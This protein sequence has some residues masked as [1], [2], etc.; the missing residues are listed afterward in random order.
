MP[1]HKTN[2][3][4]KKRIR[5]S[6]TGKVMHYKTGRRHLNSCHNRKTIRNLNRKASCHPGDAVKMLRMLGNV[7][8]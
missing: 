8:P 1:K 5:V 3:S 7:R 2:K 6:K 4:V